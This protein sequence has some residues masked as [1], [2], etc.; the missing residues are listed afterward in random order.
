MKEGLE[1]DFD[2]FESGKL[3]YGNF[4]L[5]LNPM[6]PSKYDFEKSGDYDLTEY[7]IQKLFLNEMRLI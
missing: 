3:S 5:F 4:S 7:Q 2:I 1:A 6:L